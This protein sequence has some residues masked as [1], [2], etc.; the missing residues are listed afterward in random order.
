MNDQKV[1]FDVKLIFYLNSRECHDIS[2]MFEVSFYY[3]REDFILI[4]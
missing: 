2:H 3:S 4:I 1:D